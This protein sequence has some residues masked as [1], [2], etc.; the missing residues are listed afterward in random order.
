[1]HKSITSIRPYLFLGLLAVVLTSFFYFHLYDYLTLN[2]LKNYQTTV[3]QWTLAHYNLAICIYIL[4]FTGLIACTIP[5]ATFLTLVGGFLF[6]NIA[7]FYAVFSTTLGGFILFLTVR[8]TIGL[9]ITKKSYRW[10]KKLEL[11]FKQNAFNY[12]LTLR[13]VPIF[14]CWL[15]N[16]SAGLLNVPSKTFLSATILGVA[17]STLIYVMAGRGLDK[18]LDNNNTPI[19]NILLTPSILFT[20]FGLVVLSIIPILYKTLKKPH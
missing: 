16:V 5:C 3:Q 14:P 2:T 10:V 12:L 20:L 9:H 6:G 15:S 8:S 13:L 17:P 19:T 1:M 18:I 7:F 4:T 11:G